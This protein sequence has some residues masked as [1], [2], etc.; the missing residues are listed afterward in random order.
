MT[1][2]VREFIY[3][4]CRTSQFLDDEWIWPT[5]AEIDEQVQLFTKLF[6]M[7]PEQLEALEQCVETDPA[8][9]FAVM[10]TMQR[11]RQ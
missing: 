7:T 5:E 11:I 6:Q 4:L 8:K 10:Q 1:T 9:E 3:D 2:D